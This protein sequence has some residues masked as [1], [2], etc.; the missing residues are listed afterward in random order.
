MMPH[1]IK[2][3]TILG[4][5]QCGYHA[6]SPLPSRGAIEAHYNDDAYRQA[7]DLHYAKSRS[8]KRRAMLRALR[9]WPWFR[10]RTV[11]DIGCGG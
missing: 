8:R 1:Y 11:L 9:L 7:D 5:R 6:V 4:C 3:W 10:G 2:E